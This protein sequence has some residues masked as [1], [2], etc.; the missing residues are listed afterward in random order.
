M[1]TGALCNLGELH[2]QLTNIKRILRTGTRIQCDFY[3]IKLTP[4][5]CF[6]SISEC[7]PFVSF[8]HPF[9][10]F[11][12][13]EFATYWDSSC[14]HVE[15]WKHGRPKIR[16][17]PSPNQTTPFCTIFWQCGKS[18]RHRLIRHQRYRL[19][20]EPQSCLAIRSST[21]EWYCLV[22]G[23]PATVNGKIVVLWYKF[24]MAKGPGR[25]GEPTP[26]H[27]AVLR[28][29]FKGLSVWFLL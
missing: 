21:M 1:S 5:H 10:E 25:D 12:N 28:F 24:S 19:C 7:H 6:Q 20:I 11:G 2:C 14:L 13:L 3:Q 9:L 18:V 15:N 23:C 16:K 4:Q 29:Q 8:G 26:C 22:I 27:D 17:S